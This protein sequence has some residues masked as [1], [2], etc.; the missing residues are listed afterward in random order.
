MSQQQIVTTP[1][2]SGQGDP[3]YTAFNKCNSNFTQL[4]NLSLTYATMAQVEATITL[5]YLGGT[6][7]SAAETA[8]P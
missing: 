6:T 2:N 4:Y 5:S 3:A 1:V 7:L 8:M